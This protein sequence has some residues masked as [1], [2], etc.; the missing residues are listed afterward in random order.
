MSFRQQFITVFTCFIALLL[1]IVT[2]SFSA[3][4]VVDVY[5]KGGTTGNNKIGVGFGHLTQPAHTLTMNL[6]APNGFSI[7]KSSISGG[8]DSIWTAEDNT[9]TPGAT[10][11]Y[12]VLSVDF[13]DVGHAILFEGKISGGGPGPGNPD[14]EVAVA[15]IN[16]KATGVDPDQ[17]TAED[18]SGN[19]TTGL[20]IASGQKKV[21]VKVNSLKS[22][23]TTVTSDSGVTICKTEDG[24]YSTSIEFSTGVGDHDVWVR[25]TGFS[26]GTVE[27]EFQPANETSYT[28]IDK[29]GVSTS[30]FIAGAYLGD[31]VIAYGDT[32]EY[33]LPCKIRNNKGVSVAYGWSVVKTGGAP[34]LTIGPP[35]AGSVTIPANSWADTPL[36]VKLD[37]NSP[38]GVATLKLTATAPTPFIDNLAED[39]GTVTIVAGIKKIIVDGSTPE[40]EGP[41]YT[42]SGE[43]ITLRAKPNPDGATFPTD[44]PVWKIIEEPTG[45]NLND[46]ASGSPTAN[47][48]PVVPGKYIIKAT[49]G[50]LSKTFE[51]YEVGIKEIVVDGTND[52]GPASVCLSE[53]IT[54]RAKPYPNTATFPTDKPTWKIK[55]EPTGSSLGDPTPGSATAEI[56]P[57]IPGKYIIEVSCGAS[58]KT[59]EVNAVGIK[60]IVVDGSNNTGPASVCPSEKITLRAKPDPSTATFPTGKPT[61]KIKEEPTGSSLGDPTPG[62]STAEITPVVP[63]KYVIEVSCGASIKTFDIYAVEIDKIIV[64]GSTPEEE[65]PIHACIG[66]QF[67]LRAKPNPGT[68]S[69]PAGKPTWDVKKLFETSGWTSIGTNGTGATFNITLTE[70]GAYRATATCGTS[71]D[72]FEINVPDMP[73]VGMIADTQA[74]EGGTD[75]ITIRFVRIAENIDADLEVT[76]TEN[77]TTTD[78]ENNADFQAIQSNKITISGGQTSS[79]T[80]TLKAKV[81]GAVEVNETFSLSIQDMPCYD[82]VPYSQEKK[83]KT[84]TDAF[85]WLNFYVVE[86]V[87]L[88]VKGGNDTPLAVGNPGIHINDIAQGGLGDC[89]CM[90]ALGA[91]TLECWEIIEDRITEIKDNTGKV[92]SYEV[93]LWDGSVWKE[94]SVSMELTRGQNAAQFGD[95]DPATGYAEIWPLVLEDAYAQL[96]GGFGVINGG[97][98]VSNVYEALTRKKDPNGSVDV[99]GMTN[100]QIQQLIAD[101]RGAGKQVGIGTLDTLS[102]ATIAS[103]TA[104]KVNGSKIK[105]IGNH[106]YIFVGIEPDY[107]VLDNPWGTTGRTANV[108]LPFDFFEDAIQRLYILPHISCPP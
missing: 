48:T 22:G 58:S 40:D 90:A 32:A 38:L 86:G 89:F 52:T 42:C 68:A 41:V 59:F 102:P 55:E 53:K 76:F 50:T 65:G 92:I 17:E 107:I 77:F 2:P 19:V 39:T 64:D 34:T 63:G 9:Q 29:L 85:Q 67:T 72:T 108:R 37:S 81:D 88:F 24:M 100:I 23:K 28:A 62:S 101:A 94:F 91:V 80:Y 45:S 35:A 21:T 93:T 6:N 18:A 4:E 51:I 7:K 105:L 10:H 69:F 60:E 96:V 104:D 87:T 31:I 74:V 84:A 1:F 71:T 57:I 98:S 33:D 95:I 61:W 20:I 11:T 97:G 47:I 3:E 12:K 99:T 25:A 70:Q 82:L 5:V 54:L 44:N 78:F 106:A 27:A 30:V 8:G 73:K 13:D 43:S 103:T 16:I 49:S 56:T 14:F 36:K 83:K 26:T 79:Q 66:Q 15:E 75:N 46:P